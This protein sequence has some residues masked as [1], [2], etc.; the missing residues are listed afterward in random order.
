MSSLLHIMPLKTQQ[1]KYINGDEQPEL[2]IQESRKS[3]WFK[4]TIQK[5]RPGVLLLQKLQIVL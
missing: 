1:N 4:I 2:S 3:F 5:K